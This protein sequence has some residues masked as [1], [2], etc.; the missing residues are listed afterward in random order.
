MY[1]LFS[2]VYTDNSLEFTSEVASEVH[3]TYRVLPASLPRT[4]TVGS[5][6]ESTG[7][8]FVVRRYT[9]SFYHLVFKAA[10]AFCEGA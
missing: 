3:C 8:Q 6:K 4:E 9:N 2:N 1:K 7:L 10:D 5:I